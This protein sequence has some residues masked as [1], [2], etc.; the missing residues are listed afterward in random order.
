MTTL[1]I[2]L[3]VN[4]ALSPKCSKFSSSKYSWE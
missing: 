4:E 1:T 3:P 2:S